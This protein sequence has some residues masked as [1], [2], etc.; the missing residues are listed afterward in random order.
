MPR[1]SQAS[2]LGTM[3]G[4]RAF[5]THKFTWKYGPKK[6]ARF[7]Y[8]TDNGLLRWVAVPD[9]NFYRIV[10]P[11][12]TTKNVSAGLTRYAPF[13]G[14]GSYTLVAYDSFNRVILTESVLV[15]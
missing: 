12:G 4:H 6:E 2:H 3:I 7:A 11:A 1:P 10:G 13:E 8:G 9:V 14:S 5:T 15:A